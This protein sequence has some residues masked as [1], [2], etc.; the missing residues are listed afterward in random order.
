MTT[1]KKMTA[2]KAAKRPARKTLRKPAP[3]GKKSP[4]PAPRS[5]VKTRRPTRAQ[6]VAWERALLA[7]KA[8]LLRQREFT[9]EVMKSSGPEGSGDLSSHR[10]HT[11]DQGTENYQREMAGRFRTMEDDTLRAIEEALRRIADGTYGICE[12][13]GAPIPKARLEIVPHARFCM[14]CLRAR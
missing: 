5:R 10:T 7:E 13:C 2:R 6:L 8:R 3:T 1:K 12:E 11:A 14:K 9:E 4:A